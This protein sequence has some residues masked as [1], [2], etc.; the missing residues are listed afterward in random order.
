MKRKKKKRPDLW[1]VSCNK[2]LTTTEDC[3]KLHT[4]Q[5]KLSHAA[6]DLI[7]D[8]LDVVVVVVV[9]VVSHYCCSS[10]PSSSSSS[11]PPT[12]NSTAIRFNQ[13]FLFFFFYVCVCV[14]VSV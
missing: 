3:S 7:I 12:N 11:S 8:L 6:A 9:D 10:S 13:S 2:F 1:V 14:C 4:P 5:A